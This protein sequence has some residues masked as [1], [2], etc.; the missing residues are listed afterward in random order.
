[1]MIFLNEKIPH[2]GKKPIKEI[3]IPQNGKSLK[4]AKYRKIS[5]K[6]KKTGNSVKKRKSIKKKRK[7]P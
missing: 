1:M 2:K 5:L 4:K 3:K 7:S 6:V